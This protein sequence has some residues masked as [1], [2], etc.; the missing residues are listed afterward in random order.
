MQF[1]SD[2]HVQRFRSIRDAKL[3][4]LGDFTCLCGLNNAGKSNFLRAICAF[5]TDTTD[6]AMPVSID[7]D[8]YVFELSRKQRKAISVEVGFVLPSAF[9]FR[10]GLKPAEDLLGRQFRIRKEWTRDGLGASIFLNGDSNP[11]GV[12]NAVKVQQFLSLVTARYIPNRV[13]P[14]DVIAKEHRALRDVLVRRLSKSKTSAT[15][16]FDQLRQ[17]SERQIGDLSG[18]TRLIAPDVETVRLATPGSLAEMVF[19][20]GYRLI[21]GD[22]E[23]ADALQGSGL[24]SFLMLQTLALIDNDRFQQFGWRQAA[25]W[26]VEEPESSLH[27]QLE[28]RTAH[29]LQGIAE[30]PDGRMQL[31]ATTHSDLMVQYSDR[32]FM[33]RKAKA[34]GDSGSKRWTDVEAVEPRDALQRGAAEG[35]MRYSD[36]VLHCPLSPLVLTE[37]RID[38]DVLRLAFKVT[39]L[40]D[41]P[42]VF[43]LADMGIEDVTGGVGELKTYIKQRA[44]AIKTRPANSSVFVLLDWEESNQVAGIQRFVSQPQLIVQAWPSKDANPKLD[45][46]FKGIERFLSDRIVQIAA[47]RCSAISTTGSGQRT[48]QQGQYAVV[49]SELRRAWESDFRVEDLHWMRP[50]LESLLGAL[51]VA[52]P[53]VLSALFPETPM[54]AAAE[55]LQ[56]ST[57]PKM[58]LDPKTGK[59]VAVG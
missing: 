36:P 26:L 27:A 9:K 30:R 43:C 55:I 15:S 33:V 39:A 2:V 8:F 31:I 18:Q 59:L 41:P 45:E 32:C 16:L 35:V 1:L 50:M 3:T 46:S 37:G 40:R 6:G 13:L 49:K 58:R 24:Q 34:T 48:V 52:V 20:F 57:R 17:K 23:L 10:P 29:Y 44:G 11:L 25:I 12:E 7:S 5:F 56:K 38:R 53:P 47:D 54:P 28:A 51:G 19:Q 42:Q 22:E 4:E 21:E 14:L